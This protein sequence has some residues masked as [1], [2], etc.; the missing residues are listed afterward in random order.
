MFVH[1]VGALLVN[2]HYSCGG[3]WPGQLTLCMYKEKKV[4]NIKEAKFLIAKFKLFI[5]QY[6]K[7]I[8]LHGSL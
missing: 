5:L 7:Y 3:A 2:G 6:Q 4:I 8:V 1:T